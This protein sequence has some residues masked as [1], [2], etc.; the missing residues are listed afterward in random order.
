M[1]EIVFI[2]Y[3][4]NDAELAIYLSSALEINNINTWLDI[5]E[6]QGG[7]N[8]EKEIKKGL[9][10]STSMIVLL[11]ETSFSSNYI[12]NEIEYALL[13]N[14]LQNRILPVFIKEKENINYSKLPWFL[15]KLNFV[16]IDEKKNQKSNV[17]HI[18]K[19]YF[20]MIKKWG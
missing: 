20:R 6:I 15:K 3:A 4:R 7:Q 9:D 8:I 1:N 14:K 10:K 11:R 13:N 12:R 2:S 18:T 16:V 5:K 19:E 17:N